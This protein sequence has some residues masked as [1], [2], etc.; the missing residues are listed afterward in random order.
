[1]M[2]DQPQTKPEVSL[3][4]L[5]HNLIYMRDRLLDHAPVRNMRQLVLPNG[6][7]MQFDVVSVTPAGTTWK[8]CAASIPDALTFVAARPELGEENND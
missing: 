7:R 6:A 8:L 4:A 3:D 1:M 5:I 2:T